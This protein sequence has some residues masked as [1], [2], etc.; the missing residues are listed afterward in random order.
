[1]RFK[2]MQQSRENGSDP[3]MIGE[4]TALG[5]ALWAATLF[6]SHKVFSRNYNFWIENKGKHYIPA[7]AIDPETFNLVQNRLFVFQDR[8]LAS[9]APIKPL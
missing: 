4:F 3:V 1:M 9:E 5:N 6:Q 2:L 7:S 8:W